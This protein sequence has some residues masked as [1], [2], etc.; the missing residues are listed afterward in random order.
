[1]HVAVMSAR[2][3]AHAAGTHGAPSKRPA[4]RPR[5]R[6]LSTVDGKENFS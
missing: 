4:K 6:R 5:V 1:M 2:L 3:H